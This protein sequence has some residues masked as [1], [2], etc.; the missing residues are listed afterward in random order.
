MTSKVTK[1]YKY[2]KS[3]IFHGIFHE[4]LGIIMGKKVSKQGNYHN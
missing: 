4:F 3:E 1:F 2:S